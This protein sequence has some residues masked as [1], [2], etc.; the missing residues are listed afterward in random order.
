MYNAP[1][2]LKKVQ[3]EIFSCF[4]LYFIFCTI[5]PPLLP[6]VPL[7]AIDILLAK[8]PME[9]S[10]HANVLSQTTYW[11]HREEIVL[12]SFIKCIFQNCSDFLPHTTP[13]KIFLKHGCICYV[14]IYGVYFFKVLLPNE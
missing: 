6:T 8:N 9:K 7:Q 13:K 12:I 14:T 3:N 11:F 2:F 5:F 4:F 10:L 1:N